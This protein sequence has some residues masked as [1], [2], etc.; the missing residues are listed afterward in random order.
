MHCDTP[1]CTIIHCGYQGAQSSA[2][3]TYLL[4]RLGTTIRKAEYEAASIL[5]NRVKL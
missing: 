5:W 3:P 1:W 2:Y 4:E